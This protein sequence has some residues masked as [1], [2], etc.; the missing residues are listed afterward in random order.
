[1]DITIIEDDYIEDEWF[2]NI[3]TCPKCG[4]QEIWLN[5][6]Y[7]PMCGVKIQFEGG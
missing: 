5:F 6:N 4:E 7:C 1:M 3:Y 2:G